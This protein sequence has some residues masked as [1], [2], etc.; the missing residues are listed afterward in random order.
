MSIDRAIAVKLINFARK[1][2]KPNMAHKVIIGSFLL[3]ALLNFHTLLF[4][5]YEQNDTNSATNIINATSSNENN[6]TIVTSKFYCAS[7]VGWYDTFLYPYFDWIDL[8]V[9]TIIPFFIMAIC[10]F[11]IVKVLYDSKKRLKQMGK[12]NSNNK[13]ETKELIKNEK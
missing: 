11:I 6:N 8:L 12:K 5:G 4:L 1:Y 2:C 10:T 9:Y 13:V 7:R 3:A